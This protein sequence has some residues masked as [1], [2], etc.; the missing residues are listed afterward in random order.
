[1]TDPRS[2]DGTSVNLEASLRREVAE[3]TGLT[4]ADLLISLPNL[5]GTPCSMAPVSG[6]SEYYT[7]L[8]AA[9]PHPGQPGSRK[10]A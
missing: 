6:T 8:R 2:V 3:E 9:R 5:I 4:S 1:M 10:S 7:R